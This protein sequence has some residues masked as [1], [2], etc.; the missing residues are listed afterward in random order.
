MHTLF[1]AVVSFVSFFTCMLSTHFMNQNRPYF[2]WSAVTYC[3]IVNKGGG[4]GCTALRVLPEGHRR[5]R[6]FTITLFWR[7]LHNKLLFELLKTNR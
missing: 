6:E 1:L 3:D 5:A 2:V 4:N 7:D